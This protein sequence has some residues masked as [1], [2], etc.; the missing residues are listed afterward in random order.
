MANQLEEDAMEYTEEA[1]VED[2][3]QKVIFKIRL[4]N[5]GLIVKKSLFGNTTT[6]AT[7]MTMN[8]YVNLLPHKV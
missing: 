5:K 4:D 2:D 7:C 6:R 3:L 8:E 1:D